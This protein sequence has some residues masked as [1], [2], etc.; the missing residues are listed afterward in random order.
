M[1]VTVHCGSMDKVLAEYPDATFD[2]VVTDPPYGIS[3]MGK[4][5][6]YDVPTVEQWQHC[7]RVLKPGGHL[8][9]F[10]S[11]RTQHRMAVNI[12]DAGF[13]IRD[14]VM[15]IY[16]SGFPK[17]MDV[18]KAI[19]KLDAK[20][21]QRGRRLRFTA[22]V[23]ST[24]MTAKQ[25]DSATGTNMGGHYTTASSQPAI[26][27]MEHLNACRH[28]IGEVP[29]WV[30][31]E[32]EIRSVESRNFASR[33]VLG[34]STNGIAGGTGQHVGQNNSY[35]FAA[36]FAITAPATDAARQ[37][38]GWGTALKPAYEPV[39][40]ARK[41]LVGTVAANVLQYGTGAI[42]IDGCRSPAEKATGW[43]GGGS[44][45][46]EGG[47]S[48]EGGEPRPTDAGRW[49]ANVIHDGSDEVTSLFP[50]AK[51]NDESTS[52]ARFFYVAKP[53]KSERGDGN[54]HP[55]VKPIALMRY[56]TRLVTPPNGKVLDPF[57]GSGT[58]GVA[59]IAEGFN[60]TLVE[61]EQA[62]VDIINS[63]VNGGADADRPV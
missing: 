24:G 8:L 23:R 39:I 56:L 55:T 63:R 22:W 7:L 40:V 32:C 15:W 2:A 13:E 46:H 12:E 6:D 30:E 5:W 59:C 47:L 33:E 17:S 27:T 9:S 52:A 54:N 57:A 60:C 51:A 16:G 62:Y 31:A 35:G 38:Q 20:D 58:T 37:W 49:P 48:R 14:C 44:K 18:S 10:A 29:S 21:E 50:N 42:N 53:S 19:D 61:G 45:L 41:P 28:L 11:A 25:I 43:G 26:M 3:F 36:E 4:G 1:A 34:K